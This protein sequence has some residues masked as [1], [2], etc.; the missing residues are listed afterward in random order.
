MFEL[1]L[2]GCT[3]ARFLVMHK[4]LAYWTPGAVVRASESR[5]WECEAGHGYRVQ[6]ENGEDRQN[7]SRPCSGGSQLRLTNQDPTFFVSSANLVTC[8]NNHYAFNSHKFVCASYEHDG[9]LA[10]IDASNAAW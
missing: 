7:V 4:H 6:K 5:A 9:H 3:T 10:K 2:R 1:L 8:S